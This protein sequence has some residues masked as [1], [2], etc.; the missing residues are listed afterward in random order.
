MNR[1]KLDP[2]RH[3]AVPAALLAMVAMGLLAETLPLGGR[4]PQELLA[5]FGNL[6]TP[7]PYSLSIWWVIYTGMAMFTLYQFLPSQAD[8]PVV[9]LVDSLFLTSSLLYIAWLVAWHFM[10]TGVSAVLM[11]LLT[12]AVLLIYLQ[13]TRRR[14]DRTAAHR[15]MVALPFRVYLGWLTVA[16]MANVMSWFTSTRSTFAPLGELGWALVLIAATTV[17]GAL[18]LLLKK[19]LFFNLALIWGLVAI[20]VGQSG[21]LAVVLAAALGAVLLLALI[22][23]QVMRSRRPLQPVGAVK[24]TPLPERR[25]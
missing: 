5:M 20:A 7:A 14:N 21:E 9:S 23:L 11:T 16:L 10:W 24:Q 18:M 2:I 13:V 3:L 6:F 17:I 4:A 15:L 19:D 8:D 12:A 1:L 25:H 22:V